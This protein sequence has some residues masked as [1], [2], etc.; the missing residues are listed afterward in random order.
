MARVQV[1]VAGT[2]GGDAAGQA[3][4]A[5]TVAKVG[6]RRSAAAGRELIRRWQESGLRA[7]EFCRQARLAPHIFYYWKRQAGAS[8]AGRPEGGTPFG[9]RSPCA[10][11]PASPPGRGAAGDADG[12]GVRWVEARPWVC[13]AGPG[14]REMAAGAGDRRAAGMPAGT[15]GTDD[16]GPGW[17]G[18]R[19]R[20]GRELRFASGASAEAVRRRVEV[21][22]QG[23][24][25]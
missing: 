14:G 12:E 8:A 4:G 10:V 5:G 25:P 21:L 6:R 9:A 19:L 18:L 1:G 16:T 24:R 15:G 11:R 23:A 22:D 7:A 3:A 2:Q 17:L 13:R 20:N